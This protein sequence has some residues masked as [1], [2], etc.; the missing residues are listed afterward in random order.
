MVVFPDPCSPTSITG[1][2]GLRARFSSCACAPIIRVISSWTILMKCWSGE[3]EASTSAP[4]AFSLTAA[5]KSFT[6]L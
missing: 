4:S 6:T 3:R 5:T 2:G 1:T